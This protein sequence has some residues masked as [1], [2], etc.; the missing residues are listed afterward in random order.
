MILSSRVIGLVLL[1]C[2][3]HTSRKGKHDYS[4][5]NEY[6]GLRFPHSTS[7]KVANW[8]SRLC[9]IE[10]TKWRAHVHV[11]IRVK[12]ANVTTAYYANSTSTF[13]PVIQLLHDVELNPGRST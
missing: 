8:D 13:R 9:I 11:T 3:V 10:N 12:R 6:F 5:T 4:F 2:L 1:L 7:V